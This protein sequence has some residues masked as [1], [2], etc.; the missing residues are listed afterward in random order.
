LT[1]DRF[2]REGLNPMSTVS[3]GLSTRDVHTGR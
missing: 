2:R 3:T 1:S